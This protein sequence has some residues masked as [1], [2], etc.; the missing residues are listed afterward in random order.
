VLAMFARQGLGPDTLEALASVADTIAQGAERKQAEQAL[1]QANEQL[2]V[3]SRRL[4]Q[5]QEDD[6][7]I[8]RG[9]FTTSWA[10]R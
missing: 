8:W 7:G 3:L 10:R 1:R 4:F 5:I 9:N 6:D 2:H